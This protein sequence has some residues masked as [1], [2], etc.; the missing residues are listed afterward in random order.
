MTGMWMSPRM[1]WAVSFSPDSLDVEGAPVPVVKGLRVE[2]NSCYGQMALSNNGTLIYLP[3][4][5]SSVG[6]VV[7]SLGR[8]GR[9]TLSSCVVITTSYGRTGR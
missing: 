3:G 7:F 6:P 5:V 4:S 8:S 2:P 9:G 1:L